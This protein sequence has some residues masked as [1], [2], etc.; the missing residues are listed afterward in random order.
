MRAKRVGKY[1]SYRA[2]LAEANEP[3]QVPNGMA[4]EHAKETL[5]RY[6]PL[7][8]QLVAEDF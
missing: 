5:G 8:K 4:Q 1:R 6:Q 2:R 7:V 3:T